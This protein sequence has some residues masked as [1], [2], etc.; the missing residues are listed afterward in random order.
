MRDSRTGRA[1]LGGAVCVAIL[2]SMLVQHAWPLWTGREIYLQTRPVDPRDMMRGDYVRLGYDLQ[3]LRLWAASPAA[4]NPGH[5]DNSVTLDRAWDHTPDVR[6]I[7]NW[8]QPFREADELVRGSLTDRVLYVQLEATPSDVPGVPKLYHA[9]SV[10]DHP[11]DGAIN[12]RGRV[13]SIY[14]GALGSASARPVL[15]MDYGIDALFVQEHTGKNIEY[16]VRS[17]HAYAV[18]AVTDSG[19]AR[20]KDLI[21]DGKRVIESRSPGS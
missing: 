21:I 14:G 13:R 5:D 18:I 8:D 3:S 10:C 7:G 11:V 6:V 2:V 20:L 12:L 19:A 17:G 1:M 9:V 16:A 15:Q 4:A